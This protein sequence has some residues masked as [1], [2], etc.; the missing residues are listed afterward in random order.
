MGR[1]LHYAIYDDPKNYREAER[2]IHIATELLHD[3]FS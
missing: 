1:T 2:E 3:R